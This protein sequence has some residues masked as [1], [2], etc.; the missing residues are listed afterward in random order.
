MKR[1]KVLFFA[2][3]KDRTNISEVFLDLDDHARVIDLKSKLTAQFPTAEPLFN[4]ALVSINREYAFDDD[5]IPN[6]AEVALF[7]PVSGG[8]ASE[9]TN[10]NN[11]PIIT[12]ITEDEISIDHLVSQIT[13]PTTG[14]ACVFTGTVRS[15]THRG[16]SHQ[17]DYLDYDA[18]I[19]MA[20]QKMH[21]VA[22]EIYK[23]WP[24]IEGIAIVQ[25]IGRLF[26]STPTII[27]ACSAGHR[28]SGVFE[29]ARYGIDR[30]KQIVP[31]WK[32]EVGPEGQVWV[33]GEYIPNRQD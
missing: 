8:S 16:G 7:P 30:L 2:M 5:P 13:L 14:A 28:D 10:K 4:S 15:E 22:D 29:A 27:I 21:Q 11:R 26:P 3:L 25:R 31:I 17:T 19:P 6:Q 24:E 9:N 20:E 23:E 32:K 12:H 18:Y 33:E 1:I